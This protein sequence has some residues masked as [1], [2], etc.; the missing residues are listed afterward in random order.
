MLVPHPKSASRMFSRL[1][2]FCTAG[3]GLG[4]GWGMTDSSPTHALFHLQRYC[5]H[6]AADECSVGHCRI[7]HANKPAT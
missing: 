4:G 6:A 1:P 2:A 3:S 5:E 7:V